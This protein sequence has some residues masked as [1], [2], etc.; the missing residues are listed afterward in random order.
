MSKRLPEAIEG[1][2]YSADVKV[3]L[4]NG[5]EQVIKHGFYNYHAKSWLIYNPKESPNTE[6][7]NVIS[8]S[9]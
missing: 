8:W 9:Y 6:G 7:W 5:T 1:E 4:S 3:T 2:E